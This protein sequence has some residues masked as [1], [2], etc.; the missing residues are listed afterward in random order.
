MSGAIDHLLHLNV[1]SQDGVVIQTQYLKG[2]VLADSPRLAM[3]NI[4]GH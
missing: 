1:G 3:A 2:P 4:S